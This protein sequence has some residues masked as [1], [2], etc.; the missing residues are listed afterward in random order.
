M[1][2][3]KSHVTTKKIGYLK[4]YQVSRIDYHPQ[5][6]GLHQAAPGY[7]GL[8]RNFLTRG[9]CR[10]N[11]DKITDTGSN[12]VSPVQRETGNLEEAQEDPG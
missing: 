12:P 5:P 11:L 1:K 2:P 7:Q 8:G 9:S 4:C 6:G 10:G 3:H